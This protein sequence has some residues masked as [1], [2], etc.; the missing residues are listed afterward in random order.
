MGLF[1]SG[2]NPANAAMQYLQQIPGAV[3][4]YY[5][6][7]I[8]AGRTAGESTGAIYDRL[9]NN[10]VDYLNELMSGYDATPGAKAREKALLDAAHN[11]AAAGGYAGLPYDQ[12]QQ[13]S[14]LNALRDDSMKQWLNTVLGI[15]G[16]GLSGQEHIADRGY[17]ASTGYG[18]IIGSSLNQAGGVAFQGQQ[19]RNQD[20][21]GLRNLLGGI[22]GGGIGLA[23]QPSLS[24]FGRKIW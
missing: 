10:P 24:A 3:Q 9:A 6:P 19:Q 15:Q 14:I 1:S 13:M 23:T 4:P 11:A 21:A 20:R 18:D 17:N 7:Y 16:T 2:K 8:N 22:L 12:E 5:E